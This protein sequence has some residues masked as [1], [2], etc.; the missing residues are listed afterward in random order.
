MSDTL[1]TVVQLINRIRPILAGQPPPVQGAVLADLL[2]TWLAG[3]RGTTITSTDEMREELLRL[4]LETV[5][6]L[7][8]VNAA[9]I[10]GRP[11]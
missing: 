3:H 7:V 5:R 6:A 8:P 11:T 4:H 1:A 2:A 10:H 9:H